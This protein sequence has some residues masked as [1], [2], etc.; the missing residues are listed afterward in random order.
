MDENPY[1]AARVFILSIFNKSSLY[2]RLSMNNVYNLLF[3]I[4]IRLRLRNAL[5]ECIFESN[6]HN[7][8]LRTY[9][10]LNILVIMVNTGDKEDEIITELN[11]I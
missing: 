1:I 9:L 5:K 7:K 10:I 3:V 6:L 4:R 8:I 2:S 11:R